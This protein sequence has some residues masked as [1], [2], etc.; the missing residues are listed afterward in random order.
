VSRVLTNV[1]L[2]QPSSYSDWE[3]TSITYADEFHFYRGALIGRG[4][5]SHV[6][7]CT[8][9]RDGSSCVVKIFKPMKS[10]KF[11][12]EVLVLK[13]LLGGPNIV[14]LRDCYIDRENNE[15]AIVFLR[16]G[17]VNWREYYPTLQYNDVKHY[18]RELLRGIEYAHSKG[19]I[20]R[21]LK[22][23]NICI[24]PVKRE[25]IIIDWGLAEFY[26]PKE[27]FNLRVASRY[28]KPPEILLGYRQYDYSFDL[29]SV[30]C[31]L[32][33][34]I[35]RKEVFFRGEDDTDQLRAIAAVL[36][37][38]DLREYVAKYSM[39]LAEDIADVID[40]A[41][42]PRQPWY[43]YVSWT[44]GDIARDDVLSFLDGLLRYDHRTRLSATEALAHHFFENVEE[45]STSGQ[46]REIRS[47]TPGLD[48]THDEEEED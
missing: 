30:G 4:K 37:G 5:Y 15:P 17:N 31:I 8:D 24:D 6:Y 44:N 45:S 42:Q 28:F 19:I 26:R 14:R 41:S 25:L 33:G 48:H 18:M 40:A 1:V 2:S 29:W 34:M 35:F 12:R 3:H 23:H 38:P 27:E 11:K 43:E 39:T 7:E 13:N 9:R 32:A 36:G 20:H 10:R 46:H 16:C 47:P 21:D 22:P